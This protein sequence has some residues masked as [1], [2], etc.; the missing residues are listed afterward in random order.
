MVNLSCQVIIQ[1]HFNRNRSIATAVAMI[2]KSLGQVVGAVFIQWLVDVFGWRGTLLIFSAV[3]LHIFAFA[4]SFRPPLNAKKK[5]RGVKEVLRKICDFS[6][7]ADVIFV[8]FCTSFVLFKFNNMA[9]YRHLPSRLV[10]EGVSENI[11]A[12]LLS[13]TGV[14]QLAARFIA[15]AL[16]NMACVN[17]TLLYALSNLLMGSAT[18]LVVLS[19]NFVYVSSLTSLVGSASGLANI[20]FLF[21]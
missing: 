13:V 10:H 15:G 5:A 16:G 2:G 17:R 21:I 6:M 12:A 20:I 7:F 9:Y 11:A 19:L 3:F 4:I 14:A 18:L 8:L 1:Q